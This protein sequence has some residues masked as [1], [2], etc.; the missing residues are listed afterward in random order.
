M[1][2]IVYVLLISLFAGCVSGEDPPAPTP[3]EEQFVLEHE[4]TWTPENPL[5]GEVVTFSLMSNVET[6]DIQWVY[7]DGTTGSKATHTYRHSG[8]F[9]I[10]AEYLFANEKV[11][12]RATLTIREIPTG[13][14]VVPDGDP[15]P[16][17]PA[18]PEG[19]PEPEELTT[20]TL[21][22][23]PFTI[24]ADGSQVQLIATSAFTL[25]QVR[26][27]DG[28]VDQSTEHQYLRNGNW[29]ISVLFNESMQVETFAIT[30][31][32]EPHVVV[33]IPDSGINPYHEL[34]YRPHR[35]EH[36]CTYVENFPCNI[37]ALPLSVGKYNTYAEAW[38][39]D[40]EI[41]RT[42]NTMQWFWIPQTTFIAVMCEGSTNAAGEADAA[43]G[44][45][46]LCLIDDSSMHGTGTT[47]SVIMENPDALLIFKEGN[48]ATNVF[49][50]PDL[51][52]DIISYSWG[53]AVP[54]VLGPL[55]YETWSPF[56]VAASGNEGAFPVILEAQKAHPNIINVGA[57]DSE[58]QTEP[59]YSGWKTMDYVSEYC[60]PTAQT[61]S[62]SEI[63]ER[64]CGTSFSAPTL[65][66]A[67]SL[68]ILELRRESGYSGT[69]RDGMVDPILGVDKWDVRAAL[70]ST[71]TYEPK[72]SYDSG[73][74]TV[75][76]VAPWYQWGWGYFAKEQVPAAL[77]CIKNNVC[78][79]RPDETV[80]Y[81]EALWTYRTTTSV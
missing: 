58:T 75:P 55:F 9:E 5:A 21:A 50:N 63:R 60:R 71:A 41:F 52:I 29:S 67:L 57:G 68:I 53:A 15:A 28:T 59:G 44:V 2:W 4:L 62:I 8:Q 10:V 43:T 23:A 35:T 65:A 32:F 64:Y 26:W 73:G 61:Q 20:I 56:F 79:S 48:S 18:P 33:A 7:G 1:K 46:D 22:D 72:Q 14:P 31:G 78:P 77:D 13:T 17:D 37:P 12:V 70:N 25:N 80:A 76:L 16:A 54:L 27:G 74:E 49:E 24:E 39:A 81:M 40:E 11:E 3:A 30:T 36:P 45:E 42:M 69:M 51:Q 34:Y 6:D 66:G 38:A 19:Q 47:S